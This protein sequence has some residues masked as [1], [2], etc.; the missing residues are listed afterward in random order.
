VEI[1]DVLAGLQA[2]PI[3]FGSYNSN[4]FAS[5]DVP[6]GA[7][8]GAST[9]GYSQK[10]WSSYGLSLARELASSLGVSVGAAGAVTRRIY[11]WVH[12]NLFVRPMRRRPPT[13]QR[14]AAGLKIRIW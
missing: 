8:P 11:C 13:D 1:A 10:F 6:E 14:V 4:H 2:R 7:G 5:R 9:G 3:R 12:A